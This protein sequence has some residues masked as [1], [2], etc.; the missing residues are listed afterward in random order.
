MSDPGINA[1]Q[2]RPSPSRRY[3]APQDSPEPQEGWLRP[4]YTRRVFVKWFTAPLVVEV[5]DYTILEGDPTDRADVD[6]PIDLPRQL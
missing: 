5:A 2:S 3:E 1:D 6:L 4:A